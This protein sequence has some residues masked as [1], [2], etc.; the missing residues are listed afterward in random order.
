M[1]IF[2]KILACIA[3]GYVL[4][5][6]HPSYIIAKVKKRDIK[7]EGT[8]NYGTSNTFILIGKGWGALVGVIDI[9]KGALA[10]LIP[11]WIF[12]D[13]SY[14]PYIA[15]S[16][17]VIGHI[18]P[19]YMHFDGGK[20]FAAYIGMMMA[21]CWWF[22]L[23]VLVVMVALTFAINYMITSTMTVIISFPIF[24]ACY[25]HN[26]IGFGVVLFTTCIIIYK[27]IPNFKKIKEGTEPKVRAMFAKKKIAL[28]K[29][30]LEEEKSTNEE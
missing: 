24:V 1:E 30:E 13:I 15:G 8:K 11:M 27:H 29:D 10:T 4:G 3:I 20:G 9:G 22:G 26:W 17:A 25:F 28:H 18:F 2:L 5:M 19:F 23:I 7:N 16:M 12:P 21:I 14:L 6:I